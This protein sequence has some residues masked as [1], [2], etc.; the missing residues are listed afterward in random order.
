MADADRYQLALFGKDTA[1]ETMDNPT[2]INSVC[3]H[4]VVF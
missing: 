4:V 1:A 3:V 2:I